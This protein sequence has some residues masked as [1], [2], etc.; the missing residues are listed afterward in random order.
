MYKV[1]ERSKVQIIIIFKYENATYDYF[2]A[3]RFGRLKFRA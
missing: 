3:S 1:A 2:Y